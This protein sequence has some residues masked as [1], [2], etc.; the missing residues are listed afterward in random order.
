MKL[1]VTIVWIWVTKF[2]DFIHI[3]KAILATKNDFV[4][5][6]EQLV[7]MVTN[8]FVAK[9]YNRLHLATKIFFIANY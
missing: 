7:F 9:T 6:G 2:F 5:K 4:A 3:Q 1:F 8:L